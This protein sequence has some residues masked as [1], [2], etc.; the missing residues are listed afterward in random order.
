MILRIYNLIR[1]L[2]RGFPTESEIELVQR[3][4][5]CEGKQAKIVVKG[6]NER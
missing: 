2:L 1:T 5:C 3:V 6:K 4:C